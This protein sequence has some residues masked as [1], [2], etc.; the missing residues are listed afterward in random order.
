MASKDCPRAGRSTSMTF[1]RNRRRMAM[2]RLLAMVIIAGTAPGL[3]HAGQVN[4]V[5]AV[6]DRYKHALGGVNAIAG[7]TVSRGLRLRHSKMRAA[8]ADPVRARED[9]GGIRGGETVVE[10]QGDYR[11]LSAPSRAPRRQSLL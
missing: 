5:D 3:A 1:D 10:R 6:L 8:L 11:S 4:S 9:S 7:A 2:R